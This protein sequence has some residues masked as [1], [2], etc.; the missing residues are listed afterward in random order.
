MHSLEADEPSQPASQGKP[1]AE[2]LA[3]SAASGG[4]LLSCWTKALFQQAVASEVV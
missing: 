1:A 2:A 4:D 3:H